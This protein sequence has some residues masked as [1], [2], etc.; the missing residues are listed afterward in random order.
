MAK[1]FIGTHWGT[2][3]HK[4]KNN[5]LQLEYW[6]KDLNPTKFGIDFVNAAQDNLRIKQPYIRKGWLEHNKTSRG[7][8]IFIPVSWNE[9]IL[10]A[11]NELKRIKKKYGN[12]SIY[13]GSYGWASAGL[14]LIHI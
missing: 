9:A 4:I 10:Y 3:T 13:A 8:D 6:G 5:K 11:S 2:Y 1:K 7:K 12:K 14:S